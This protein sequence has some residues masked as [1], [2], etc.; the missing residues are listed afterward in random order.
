MAPVNQIIDVDRFQFYADYFA[1]AAE[2]GISG[3]QSMFNAFTTIALVDFN[4]VDQ[5]AEALF[6]RN[7]LAATLQTAY[8]LL[9]TNADSLIPMRDSFK[10]LG[11]HV[12][13]FGHDSVDSYL[14]EN[15][16]KVRRIYANIAN[17]TGENIQADNIK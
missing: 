5:T 1:F 3:A 12:R 4:R 6:A 14:T 7:K 13:K 11:D 10:A 2:S 8:Q 9:F 17:L 16:I 15:G